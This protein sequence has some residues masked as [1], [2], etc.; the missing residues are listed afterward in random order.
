MSFMA[1]HGYVVAAPDHT[2]NTTFDGS[3]RDTS[4]YYQGR[5]GFTLSVWVDDYKY[6][7]APPPCNPTQVA[8][9]NKAGKGSIKG[10]YGA[11]VSVVCNNGFLGGGEAVCVEKKKWIV[12]GCAQP[13]AR[14]AIKWF[15][16]G[17]PISCL[18]SVS[19]IHLPT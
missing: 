4:I 12:K 2:G 17:A 10:D 7:P 15:G 16:H 19:G 3:S 1:S 11:K 13:K 18:R 6:P 5:G 8:N 14:E 9:S